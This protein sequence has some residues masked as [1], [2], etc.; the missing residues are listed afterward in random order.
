MIPPRASELSGT[1]AMPDYGRLLRGGIVLVA[2]DCPVSRLVAVAGLTRWGAVVREAVDGRGALALA[3]AC[4]FDFMLLDVQMP[5]MDGL[6]ATR[7]IRS[8]GFEGGIFAL[9]AGGRPQE[10]AACLAAGMDGVL[11]KPFSLA[12][13]CGLLS[14]HDDQSASI[15]EPADTLI[16]MPLLQEICGGDEAFARRMLGIVARELPKA[17]T[18]LKEAFV[19]ADAIRMAQIAHRVRPCIAGLRLA[20][21]HETALRIEAMAEGGRTDAA[22]YQLITILSTGVDVVMSAISALQAA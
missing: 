8:A 1:P 10:G 7:A 20:G 13:L 4:P 17:I 21:L 22:L 2:D 6:T 9:S 11:L 5:L 14:G 19:A 12:K 18:G 16:S 15:P 3:A